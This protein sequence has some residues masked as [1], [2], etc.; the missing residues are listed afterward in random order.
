MTNTFAKT[1]KWLM[2]L[3]M[4]LA[5]V[6][7]AATVVLVAVSNRADANVVMVANEG[8][9]NDVL[10]GIGQ[11]KYSGETIVRLSNDIGLEGSLESNGTY[12]L[13][14]NG[15]ALSYVGSEV[16]PVVTVSNGTLTLTDSGAR[17]RV[18]GGT[19]G[20]IIV[21][22]GKL[23]LSGG[24][25]SGNTSESLGAGVYVAEGSTISVSGAPVVSGNTA[26]GAESNLYLPGDTNVFIGDLSAAANI[27]VTL[28]SERAFT[29][30]YASVA[31]GS[32][33]ATSAFSADDSD[34]KIALV[35]GEIMVVASNAV[36]QVDETS[37]SSFTSGWAQIKNDSI[38]TLLDDVI[39]PSYLT[40]SKE[41][42]TL[43]LNGHMLSYSGTDRALLTVSASNVEDRMT[44][45]LLDGD[46][47]ANERTVTNP[48]PADGE[49]ANMK[50]SGGVIYGGLYGVRVNDDGLGYVEFY[51]QGGSIMG[52][53]N[54]GIYM[55]VQTYR[56]STTTSN[57]MVYSSVH[58]YGGASASYN[59]RYGV[60]VNAGRA[61][62]MEGSTISNNGYG[63]IY[64]TNA[65]ISLSRG[66]IVNNGLSNV[67]PSTTPKNYHTGLY[68]DNSTSNLTVNGTNISNNVAQGIF[69]KSTNSNATIEITGATINNNG[70]SSSAAGIEVAGTKIALTNSKVCDNGA[71]GLKLSV[72]NISISG[73][74]ID[75]NGKDGVSASGTVASATNTS[76][77]N[78]DGNGV[79]YKGTTLTL[80]N[81]TL[82]N[83]SA[84]GAKATVTTTNITGSTINNNGAEGVNSNGVLNASSTYVEYNGNCGV[85]FSGTEITIDDCTLTANGKAHAN[86]ETINEANC[87]NVYASAVTTASFT[88]SNMSQAIGRSILLV[89]TGSVNV[90][91]GSSAIYSNAGGIN[92]VAGGG[93]VTLDGCEIFDNDSANDGAGV[94]VVMNKTASTV[95]LKDVTINNNKSALSGG[96]LYISLTPTSGNTT[97][98]WDG[99]HID[100]NT[101]LGVN[102]AAEQVVYGG[103]GAYIDLRPAA[104]TSSF[105]VNNSSVNGN[106][107]SN[108]GGGIYMY[109]H[110]NGK[111]TFT[112][113][114]FEAN[115]NVARGVY[116]YITPWGEN[117]SVKVY[118]G[119]GAV[120]ARMKSEKSD[121][122][123]DMNGATINNNT[124]PCGGGFCV[125]LI[126]AAT[127]GNSTVSIK[128]AEMHYNTATTHYFGGLYVYYHRGIGTT[129]GTNSLTM[130]K[131]NITHNTSKSSHGGAYVYVQQATDL[132]GKGTTAQAKASLKDVHIDDNYAG[133]GYGG[134]YYYIATS[135]LGLKD[136]TDFICGTVDCK[137]ENCS[138]DRNT[139]K[140][141]T[142]GGLYWYA[143]SDFGTCTVTINKTTFNDNYAYTTYGGAFITSY[144]WSGTHAT[145]ELNDCE[146]SGNTAETSHYGGAYLYLRTNGDT[147][148]L[149]NQVATQDRC[150]DSTFTLNNIVV[151]GNT[152]GGFYGGLCTYSYNYTPAAKSNVGEFATCTYTANH[153][154]ITDNT[155][156]AACGGL[157]INNGYSKMYVNMDDIT[158]T[159]NKALNTFD[160]EDGNRG[161]AGGM[162]IY[163]TSWGQYV[164]MTNT[165]IS[166]NISAVSGGGICVQNHSVEQVVNFDR[167]VKIFN[168]E[169]AIHGGG[170]YSR[171]TSANESAQ[172]TIT[173][174]GTPITGNTAEN[175]G[176]VALYSAMSGANVFNK[177]V[178]KGGVS[179]TDNVAA[180]GGGVYDG[181]NSSVDMS[182]K[183]DIYNN[184]N[185]SGFSSNL[186]L[187]ADNIITISGQLT[188]TEAIRLSF[189]AVYNNKVV[190]QGFEKNASFSNF[191]FDD[192]SNSF[193]RT[194][195]SKELTL[196]FSEVSIIVEHANKTS[197]EYYDFA[198]AYSKAVAT[199]V[200]KLYADVAISASIDVTREV[201]IDLNGYMLQPASGVELAYMFSIQ[202]GGK[203]TV[204]DSSYDSNGYSP[205]YHYIS[206]PI[207]TALTELHG[208]IIHGTVLVQGGDFDFQAGNVS[209]SYGADADE[210]AGI[211][212]EDGNITMGKYA[213]V[214]YNVGYG[215]YITK[216]A[217]MTI[218]GGKYFGNKSCA[219]IYHPN[220]KSKY[221]TLTLEDGVEVTNNG[222]GVHAGQYGSLTINGG[223]YAENLYYNLYSNAQGIITIAGGINRHG[224]YFSSTYTGWGVRLYGT[225]GVFNMTGGVICDSV[226]GIDTYSTAKNWTLN[227][228]GGEIY[229]CSSIGVRLYRN[230]ANVKLYIS[231]EAKIHDNAYGVYTECGGTDVVNISGGKI[232][233]NTVDGIR[234]R[235]FVNKG[236]STMNMTGGEIYG[237]KGSGVY[238]YG[239]Y[240][241]SNDTTYWDKSITMTMNMSGGQ[242]Y[243]NN[244]GVRLTASDYY[245]IYAENDVF[246][247][248]VGVLNMTGGTITGNTGY[249]I[250]LSTSSPDVYGK[251][252]FG[253]GSVINITGNGP[254]KTPQDVMAWS[255]W[256]NASYPI[257]SKGSS[258]LVSGWVV[259]ITFT[260]ALTAG[261]KIGIH[262]NMAANTWEGQDTRKLFTNWNANYIKGSE[263]FCDYV[264]HCFKDGV[265]ALDHKTQL[266]PAK[267]PTCTAVGNIDYY[268]CTLCGETF[269]DQE[270][271]IPYDVK[272]N[273]LPETDHN[274][275]WQKVD[276]YNDKEVCQV[277]K[278]T[279]ATEAHKYTKYSSA[280][281]ASKNYEYYSTCVKCEFVFAS[282]CE[283]NGVGHTYEG[284]PLHTIGRWSSNN[285]S[286]WMQ[287]GDVCDKCFQHI[288]ETPH[289]FD[290]TWIVKGDGK[291]Y[292][293]CV[294]C[295]KE[296]A[297][298][299]EEHDLDGVWLVSDDGK[300][301][302]TCRG[303]NQKIEVVGQDHV[304][305]GQWV[306]NEDGIHKQTCSL[307][308]MEII[309]EALSHETG[310]WTASKD[311]FNHVTNCTMCGIEIAEYHT[312]SDSNWTSERVGY[313]SR[314]CTKCDNVEEVAC[315]HASTVLTKNTSTHWWQCTLCAQHVDEVKHTVD[316]G[317]WTYLTVTN[318]RG[319]CTICN[320]D[321]VAAH[322]A[323]EGYN[324]YNKN[325][326]YHFQICA[327]CS[328][329]IN[330]E[331]HTYEW[332]EIGEEPGH[333]SGDCTACHDKVEKKEHDFSGELVGTDASGHYYKCKDDDCDAKYKFEEH[334]FVI[335]DGHT[336]DGG[337][338]GRHSIACKD[339]GY[340][341]SYGTHTYGSY[342]PLVNE[343][344]SS[345][346]H[347]RACS[348]CGVM[349]TASDNTGA[350]HTKGVPFSS[351]TGH[352]TWCAVCHFVLT[353]S[354][355]VYTYV[356]SGDGS[357]H[358]QQCSCGAIGATGTHSWSDNNYQYNGEQH[359]NL[360]DR[361]G[362]AANYTNHDKVTYTQASADG[363]YAQ[364]ATCGW[365]G[366]LVGH[367]YGE[368]LV[369]EEG[370][371][372]H[373]SLCNYDSVEAGHV[374]SKLYYDDVYGHWQQCNVC[375]AE[376]SKIDHTYVGVESNS[377]G[378]HS[379]RC[380][381]CGRADIGSDCLYEYESHT[382]ENH[383]LKC[384][385]CGYKTIEEHNKD[386][387]NNTDATNHWYECS[388]CGYYDKEKVE[389][390]EWSERATATEDKAQHFFTCTECGYDAEPTGHTLSGS[391]RSDLE[392]HW[393]LCSACGAAGEADTHSYTK[394][395]QNE[396]AGTHT[397]ICETCSYR[398]TELK[399]EYDFNGSGSHADVKCKQCDAL[400]NPEHDYSILR[401]NANHH[402]YE[403]AC[404]AK[405]NEYGDQPHAFPEKGTDAGNGNHTFTCSVC[406]EVKS[407]GHQFGSQYKFDADYHWYECACGAKDRHA[408][409]TPGDTA[410]S[411]DNGTHT[412]KC[413]DC[414]RTL[415]E[416]KCEYNVVQ[417]DD[418]DALRH[419]LVC[420]VCGYT[421]EALHNF[422][423]GKTMHDQDGHWQQCACGEE[424]LANK[425]AH[426]PTNISANASGNGHDYDCAYCEY[427][428]DNVAHVYTDGEYET[429]GDNHWQVCEICHE[430]SE[431]VA[432]EGTTYQDN[433]DGTHSTIC[434]TCEEV[435]GSIECDYVI[436]KN[437]G[438]THYK[439]C[440]DCGY[441]I[442]ED[443]SV[444]TNRAT[445]ATEH[446]YICDICGQADL[447]TVEEHKWS[448]W[449]V[450]DGGHYHYC[451]TCDYATA[452]EDHDLGDWQ[453]ANGQ[454]WKQ[455]STCSYSTE[456]ADHVFTGSAT[457]SSVHG[458]HTAICAV[459]GHTNPGVA[460][461]YVYSTT[462][463]QHI[464]ICTECGDRVEGNH[465][466]DKL[467]YDETHHWYECSVCGYVNES[468]KIAHT[469]TDNADVCDGCDHPTNDALAAA[470]RAAIRRIN[471]I[472]E[473]AIATLKGSN[474]DLLTQ[475]IEK[476]VRDATDAINHA[477][478][479]E[480][481]TSAEDNFNA[482]ITSI[483]LRDAK[484]VANAQLEAKAE[485]VEASLSEVLPETTDQET[486]KAA[487]A[488]AKQAALEVVA[489]CADQSEVTVALTAGLASIEDAILS[490]HKELAKAEI[491]AE[492][493]AAKNAIES[494]DDL[495][496][497]EIKDLVDL[498]NK[499]ADRAKGKIDSA[500]SLEEVDDEKSTGIEIIQGIQADPDRDKREEE[501][502]DRDESDSH[503][504][505]NKCQ[506]CGKCLT[507][508][509]DHADCKDKCESNGDHSGEQP[510]GDDHDECENKCPTCNKCLTPDCD[511]A[512][513]QDKCEFGGHHECENQCPVC[514]KCL[515]PDCDHAICEDKCE[516]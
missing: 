257:I 412:T 120:H 397:G 61:L 128:N 37:Y 160:T 324:E 234:M 293:V 306:A 41:G 482:E 358:Y 118:Y 247:K 486:Y 208:G 54:D 439:T 488:A 119:G 455:C 245:G 283:Q 195:A 73:S 186:F 48:F 322:V 485:E 499:E 123:V 129:G 339:C 326:D 67:E 255:Y 280:N 481:I 193:D 82:N 244:I 269:F 483:K 11:G 219:I 97:V 437:D 130:E 354:E 109:Q 145:L 433:Q 127:N 377:D 204:I 49:D 370:H 136:G 242:I 87:S 290:G 454:H 302:Q 111:G 174:D 466:N 10:A 217:D 162:W 139:A 378:T 434:D 477:T 188:T 320:Q 189:D 35:N 114:G 440:A 201:T 206:N 66:E 264:D 78:N 458:T 419:N 341:Q 507:P 144:C 168:N 182:G 76:I 132:T 103:G 262:T 334:N 80:I 472:A 180:V 52:A 70:V 398:N 91:I 325:D 468:D 315:E 259:P 385:V 284:A 108:Y 464:S 194:G 511:H 457:P 99:V 221:Y 469:Y 121:V 17:G 143:L 382:E 38:V 348:V 510:G 379:A 312:Y 289:T 403:C 447:G 456:H 138:F 183:V 60:N 21:D 179:I 436:S 493:I 211:K 299:S 448:T 256:A 83:N 277:C 154:N 30:G 199:D 22:G 459:C 406:G 156:G 395:D 2:V 401:H 63:G 94:R 281:L 279:G 135:Y 105:A 314:L 216:K 408:A 376:S 64:A 192:D 190:S 239:Y 93:S 4:V 18:T 311:G 202:A 399:C 449:Q 313:K 346:I 19:N 150:I 410:T 335:D 29:K 368:Y 224:R 25:I 176:G 363:H 125:D 50:V 65:D 153:L 388:V 84:I 343:D 210:R 407:E 478:Q 474:S 418:G 321:V 89:S 241:L 55:D 14:L 24:E 227:I 233:N 236:D 146:F 361:C 74:T 480:E 155:A 421:D 495:S 465:N 394:F 484:D 327:G 220:Y 273:E 372:R 198:T 133:A 487:I 342:K 350:E 308:K 471:I 270:G 318:H 175:G 285:T 374:Y 148:D 177:L 452:V 294:V 200:I 404:G 316:D 371:Y 124:S 501:S 178:L 443:H 20:G 85:E 32:S 393:Q 149:N 126:P 164:T 301:Y 390:H 296:V 475:M 353:S 417:K 441:L 59:K 389:K 340:S 197:T 122:S 209:N 115:Y 112:L 104:G 491:D 3:L 337:N 373:C 12:T 7:I 428:A 473:Q 512:V 116:A 170:L 169:A 476:A 310:T 215:L 307:C 226:I 223:L 451:T 107:A 240:T 254:K 113:T 360:C 172:S 426:T 137:I 271:K 151:Q 163:N 77:S 444:T 58:M 8:E 295:G 415:A 292:Q 110:A 274:Y 251:V 387:L 90:T 252:N 56:S 515:T 276:D 416:L 435:F 351:E 409:H 152:A 31:T 490:A 462:D 345:T 23:A 258:Q 323:R 33:L 430:D 266:V 405:N 365:R 287:E 86:D 357:T 275:K 159:G 278:A 260:S 68:I 9:L 181:E 424:D 214:C 504:C 413:K 40:A 142:V 344:G 253:G 98:S 117:A 167:S 338:T 463:T 304:L 225:G 396:K 333:Y 347:Y 391:Y 375:G 431:H 317:T 51:F 367:S 355:H 500:K 364:C 329:E 427:H 330:H 196:K 28:D 432:H 420:K 402:W 140:T 479:A 305:D 46:P 268:R 71:E 161:Q 494:N 513:C 26:F 272:E 429:D 27:G 15:R 470:K 425:V 106:T 450:V 232:Y 213:G 282:T 69:V 442:T 503:E 453:Q 96:G 319:K 366:T 516:F 185:S 248:Y 331:A 288:A 286:H 231:G 498:I 352:G 131:V 42:L 309:I 16:A 297:L 53:A 222:V 102:S 509:C 460:C 165:N 157:M 461:T 400:A 380:S 57:Q 369:G 171:I 62:T 303:C 43:D 207:T 205:R 72:N 356:D 489:G 392:G 100:E 336:A 505:E 6:A 243:N 328:S 230:N 228:S 237:N 79:T 467:N 184:H 95:T 263:I 141:G 332:T 45:T 446:W 414:G 34:G 1:K 101:A 212:V 36:V 291:H 88:N 203:L 250:Y 265:Y 92:V 492:A 445:N 300:H 423:G 502:K 384:K 298:D 191:G 229:N 218:S 47:T 173:F 44:F 81:S 411:N 238:L 147:Y 386:T 362:G 438:D 5:I 497:E 381:T 506:T 134:M 249:G 514:G 235:T 246:M 383:T 267:D 158:I 13:D 166:G 422:S 508:D 39:L 359:W 75:E 349:D 187:Y 261:S 496:A